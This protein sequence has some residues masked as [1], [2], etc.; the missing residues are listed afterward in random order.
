MANDVSLPGTKE[1]DLKPSSVD[2]LRQCI[3]SGRYKVVHTSAIF[4]NLF[5]RLLRRCVKLFL[6]L[7][8]VLLFGMRIPRHYLAPYVSIYHP[9]RRQD[10]RIRKP[11]KVTTDYR[12]SM[13]KLDEFADTNIRLEESIER[14]KD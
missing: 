4:E 6:S 2:V 9:L 14:W 8:G 3:R 1:E 10:S 11:T 7:K 12:Q 5:N 13:A